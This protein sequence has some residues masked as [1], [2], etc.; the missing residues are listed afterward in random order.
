MI[1]KQT[2]KLCGNS[3]LQQGESLRNQFIFKTTKG[4]DLG[5]NY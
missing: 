3:V 5:E 2:K 4:Y 1:W